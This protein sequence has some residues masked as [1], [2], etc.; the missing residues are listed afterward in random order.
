MFIVG[1]VVYLVIGFITASLDYRYEWAKSS[2][3]YDDT[4]V[5][6]NVVFWPIMFSFIVIKKW[7][8][9]IKKKK[10]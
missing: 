8:K 1:L 5:F 2:T 6:M 9:I 4:D 3:C 7:M 10:S